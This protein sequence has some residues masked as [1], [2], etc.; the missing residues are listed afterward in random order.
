MAGQQES[1]EP[2]R[3]RTVRWTD[4]A[5]VAAPGR[6]M[7]GLE[8]LRKIAVG[9]LPPPPIADLLGMRLV[10]VEPSSAAFEFDPAEF[11]Y[12]PLGTVHGGI[13]TTLLDSAMGCAVHTT[14]PAGVG[15]TTLELKVNFVRS[16][17]TRLG[18][19]RAEG[20]VVHAGPTVSTAEARLVDRSETLYAHGVSTLMILRGPSSARREKPVG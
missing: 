5:V 11:M 3:V 12:N 13:V 18:P 15:Y 7:S 16:V 8:F 9:E 10:W 20:K 1:G 2:S 4:P 19:M 6:T 14:L 17:L